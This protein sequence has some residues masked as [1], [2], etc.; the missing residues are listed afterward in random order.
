M[1]DVVKQAILTAYELVPEAYRQKFRGLRKIEGQTYVE[2]AHDKEV[3]FERWCT[4]RAVQGDF[5]ML[6]DLM[7]VEEFKR[8][9]KDDIKSYLDEKDVSTLHEA[10]K[11]AD[12]YSLTF[13]EV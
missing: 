10:A 4:S 12:G 1:Y 8:C 5:K 3:Y 2:F 13:I 11:F 6:K 9:V 7:L